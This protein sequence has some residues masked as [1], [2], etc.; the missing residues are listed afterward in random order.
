MI[1][2]FISEIIDEFCILQ[3]NSFVPVVH[4]KPHFW[5]KFDGETLLNV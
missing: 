5:G 4:E 3:V 1:N 2:E